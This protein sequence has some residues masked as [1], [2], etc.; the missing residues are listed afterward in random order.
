VAADRAGAE[1]FVFIST[2]KAVRPTSVMG[3]SKRVAEMIVRQ[4][5]HTSHTRFC[6]VRFGNVLGSA[7]SVV[8]LFRAQIAAGGPVT[9]TDPE[10]KRYFMT[11]REAVGLV[12]Q[13]GYGD[14][15]E[16][17]VLD[18]GEQIK[19]VDLARHMITMA[20]HVPDI[21]VAIE[22]MGLRPGEKLYEELLTEDEES[23][24]QVD[25]KIFVAKCPAPPEDLDARVRELAEA[26]AAEDGDRVRAVLRTLVSS[27][28]YSAPIEAPESAAA[29]SVPE[30]KAPVM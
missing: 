25:R 18:M 8:P 29:A 5:A 15:G 14:Y 22:F 19:I 2:D 6:A 3:A 10:V 9:V 7:G 11:T 20:G 12:L 21:D 26:A 27:Y 17:C 23:T 28:E 24:Q 4:L 16:L 13:A 30:P 1:R